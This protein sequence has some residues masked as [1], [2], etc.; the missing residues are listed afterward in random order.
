MR[1]LLTQL[2][3]AAVRKEGTHL[4]LIFRRLAGRMPYNKALWA[5]AHRLCRLIWQVLHEGVHDVEQGRTPTPL[6]RQRQ[7][8]VGQ[9]R[10]LGYQ[11]TLTPVAPTTT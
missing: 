3:R 11:V 10:Q 2:A 6:Q 8:L 1:R 4:Q 5:I 7:R 9:L